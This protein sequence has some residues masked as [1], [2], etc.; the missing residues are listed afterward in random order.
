MK[1]IT[2]IILGF[3]IISIALFQ[4]IKNLYFEKLRLNQENYIRS[5]MNNN[6]Y[7]FSEIKKLP[8]KLRP[9]LKYNHDFLMMRDINLNTIPSDRVLEAVQEKDS[10]LLSRSYFDRK[11]EINWTEKGPNAQ[12]GRTRALMLD[13]NYSSNNRVWAAGVSGGLWYNDDISSQSNTWTKVSDFWDNLEITAIASDPND[14]N[15]I[16]SLIHI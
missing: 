2:K 16:L 12:G 10:R 14:S 3:F 7:D 11:S 1:N 5:Y 9:D 13:G 4:P 6:T 15:I 8:K